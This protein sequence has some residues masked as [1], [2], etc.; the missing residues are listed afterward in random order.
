M[1]TYTVEAS[2]TDLPSILDLAE[3]GQEVLL[4]TNNRPLA[5]LIPVN[6][7]HAYREKILAVEGFLK[8]M[9]TP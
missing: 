5:R 2:K 3:K 1:Q 7:D 6:D 9:D 4:T 8:G